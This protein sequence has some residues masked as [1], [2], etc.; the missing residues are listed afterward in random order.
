M[1]RRA[2]RLCGRCGG[3]Y[4]GRRC[5][6]CAVRRMVREPIGTSRKTDYTTSRWR[7]TS[8]AYLAEHPLCE[9]VR[10]AAV[11]EYLRDIA[12]E[13]DHVDG[14]GPSGPRG[15][16]WGNLQALSKRHHAVKTAKH[17]GG[18]G[19]RRKPLSE[20]PPF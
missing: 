17:D 3:T 9:C 2:P 4:T 12:T 19:N 11:P 1:P 5:E 10:C 8:R 16:D 13:T 7:Q 20:T 14:L 15:F 18:F 6:V